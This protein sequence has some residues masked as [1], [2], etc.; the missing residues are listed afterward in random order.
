MSRDGMIVDG[1]AAAAVII[2]AAGDRFESKTGDKL[3]SFAQSAARSGQAV[4]ASF[5]LEDKEQQDGNRSFD[6]TI[7]PLS[8]LANDIDCVTVLATETTLQRNLTKALTASRGLF[9]DLVSCSSDFAWETDADGAF[10]FVSAKGVAGYAS[11]ALHGRRAAEL[12]DRKS[13]ESATVFLTQTPIEEVEVWLRSAGTQSHCFLIS[14]V[15]L[16]DSDGVWRGARGVGRE[17]TQL[18]RQQDALERARSRDRLVQGVADAIRREPDPMKMLSAAAQSIQQAVGANDC[19]ILSAKGAGELTVSAA[20][21]GDNQVLDDGI[22][23][24]V[25]EHDG[26]FR[27]TD[28]GRQYVTRA[29]R[30]QGAVNGAICVARSAAQSPFGEEHEFLIELVSDQAAIA[31]AQAKL[32]ADLRRLSF[33]DDLTGLPNRR[34]FFEQVERRIEHHLRQGRSAALLFVDLDDFKSLNDRLGHA[35]G[36]QALCKTASCL[37]H[38][39]RASDI[40]VRLGGDEFALWLEEIDEAGALGVA[41]RLKHELSQSLLSPVNEGGLKASIGG[42]TWSPAL[43]FSLDRLMQAADAALYEVKRSG[44]NEVRIAS[45]EEP[46]DAGANVAQLRMEAKGV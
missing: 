39:A 16:I 28:N 6:L 30:L 17:V 25:I 14:A 27:V 2:G 19:W 15:P 21:G 32:T 29:T 34:A 41:A 4:Q 31:I 13:I 22:A 42:A 18:R 44:K 37:N 20:S 12:A 7:L 24:Q 3:I 46:G 5:S 23:A 10:V 38:V 40:P 26:L 8:G 33:T 36:D 9:K 11:Q 1:N 43:G 35:V 45:P